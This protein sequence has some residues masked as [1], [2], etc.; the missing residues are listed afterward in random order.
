MG[1][2]GLTLSHY[3][4][5]LRRRWRIVASVLGFTVVVAAMVTSVMPIVYSAQATA[6]VS[7][8]SQR[9][10][11]DSLYQDSQYALNRVQSYPQLA[12]GPEILDDVTDDLGLDTSVNQLRDQVTVV[13]PVD[14]VVLEVSAE[15]DSPGRAA[16]IAN[17]LADTLGERIQE[18][19]RPSTA[20][21]SPVRVT[22]AVPATAP[23][24]PV[25]P[26][27]ALNLALGL[28]LGLALGTAAALVRDRFDTTI[29]SSD[30]I[31]SLAGASTLGLIRE[32]SRFQ[33]QPLVT[34]EADWDVVEDFRGI[35]TALRF[36]DIDR[37]PRQ[38]VITSAIPD[39]GKS[40]FACNLALILAQT[41]QSVCLVE[42]DLRRPRACDYLGVDEG[43]GLSDIVAGEVSLDGA[44][45][46]WGGGELMVIPA[47]TTPPDPSQILGSKAMDDLL[48]TLRS[49]FDHVIIDSPP[50]LAVSDAAVLGPISDGVVIVARHRLVKREQLSLALERLETVGA[51]VLGVVLNR[52]R[53]KDR[54]AR[55]ASYRDDRD[56]RRPRET[57][58][59][60]N[61]NALV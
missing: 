43:L 9:S 19:E 39:E 26:R 55:F 47:G 49:R 51:H 29:K 3:L 22:T 44:L 42:A 52:V 32:D 30:D 20:A 45:V 35:R 18:L 11:A 57:S 27:P 6:F 28:L 8:T 31:A 54:E 59:A 4:G 17:S 16:D 41:A 58:P 37:P 24:G 56:P 61:H 12:Q 13:N 36:V 46:S 2:N 38:L 14:T 10:E 7:I 5:V 21:P 40:S 53:P 23:S 60:R 50:L 1:A 15:S 34:V 25:S 48:T 33:K